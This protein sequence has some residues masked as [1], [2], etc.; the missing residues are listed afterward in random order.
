M[1]ESPDVDQA[2]V[3]WDCGTPLV[4]HADGAEKPCG[5]QGP[6]VLPRAEY[7]R[8]K[9]PRMPETPDFHAIARAAL[10]DPAGHYDAYRVGPV[11]DQLRLVWNAR[12][13]AD[14]AKLEA[15]LPGALTKRLDAAL[16]SLDR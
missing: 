13:A 10:T 7:L 3:C 9:G 1:P 12:G 4:M 8:R 6:M 11:A 14:I 16:R 15:E 2:L 5:H